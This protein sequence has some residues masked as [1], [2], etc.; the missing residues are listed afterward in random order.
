[1]RQVEA[2]ASKILVGAAVA[3]LLSG[4]A[5]AAR[6]PMTIDDS[7]DYTDTSGDPTSLALSYVDGELVFHFGADA[8]S[9][10]PAVA[11]GT[12][13]RFDSGEVPT[14][15]YLAA[16]LPGV[17]L[18]VR[19]ATLFAAGFSH[20]AG[21]LAEVVDAYVAELSDLG[22]AASLES[23]DGNVIVYEFVNDS[24]SLRGVFTAT[25]TGGRAYLATN[26]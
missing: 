7:F 18:D 4:A 8:N 24:G 10:L 14:D 22:F 23:S 3:G 6:I 26:L 21:S 13:P 17:D 19:A 16:E 11:V 9:S 2:L 20:E 1:M 5:L 12:Y 15:D 25:A